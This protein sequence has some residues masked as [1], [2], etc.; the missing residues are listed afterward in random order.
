MCDSR[1]IFWVPLPSSA[2]GAQLH[3]QSASVYRRF[4]VFVTAAT[5]ARLALSRE[6][7]DPNFCR[8][9]VASSA[10]RLD[11]RL[12]L[13]SSKDVRHIIH[14][15]VSGLPGRCCTRL[16]AQLVLD[17]VFNGLCCSR[18]AISRLQHGQRCFLVP[19][20]SFPSSSGVDCVGT[21]ARRHVRLPVF[22][23][24]QPGGAAEERPHRL[25]LPVHAGPGPLLGV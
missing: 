8:S 14:G 9:L 16:I 1:C 19:A 18:M 5:P 17:D 6:R 10:G 22:H 3:L 15:R 12:A 23:V 2:A 25:L 13:L 4:R 7:V 24:R 21:T 20:P 11:K